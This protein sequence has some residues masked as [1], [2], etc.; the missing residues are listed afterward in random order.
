MSQLLHTLAINAV[1]PAATLHSRVYDAGLYQSAGVDWSILGTTSLV[2]VLSMD[3]SNDVPPPG[4]T[5][6]VWQPTNWVAL[7]DATA[8]TNVSTLTGDGAYQ[9]R[10]DLTFVRWLRL[11]STYT[12]GSGGALSANLFMQKTV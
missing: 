9:T 8:S 5:L 6:D 4:A 10:A 2:A 12:S 1:S 7:P 3:G 11:T